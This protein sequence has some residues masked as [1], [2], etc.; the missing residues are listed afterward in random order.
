MGVILLASREDAGTGQLGKDAKVSTTNPNSS[1][2]DQLTTEVN[3]LF[4]TGETGAVEENYNSAEKSPNRLR[5]KTDPEIGFVT[6]R[7]Q[8]LTFDS[9]KLVEM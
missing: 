8:L 7:A 4:A 5:R 9:T 6:A 3:Q 2:G 1:G